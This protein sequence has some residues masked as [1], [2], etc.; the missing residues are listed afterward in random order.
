MKI[1]K[2]TRVR[3]SYKL[4]LENGEVLRVNNI[5]N[6]WQQGFDLN[7]SEL[8]DL[9]KQ[10]Q[11]DKALNR[12]YY[13]LS[14]KDYTQYELETKLKQ[15]SFGYSIIHESLQIIKS[16]GL[17]DERSIAENLLEKYTFYKPEGWHKIKTRLIT[18]GINKEVVNYIVNQAKQ[19]DEFDL[20]WKIVTKKYDKLVDKKKAKI[21][22]S[23][24]NFLLRKGFDIQ[25]AKQ[26]LNK[27]ANEQL[28]GNLE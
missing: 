17:I 11:L 21:E 7:S 12:I 22:Y 24:Y 28:D 25:T 26:V 5:E 2:I 10:D 18:K 8:I 27:L 13:L 15:K 14:L 16:R 23:L 6:R 19:R 4:L 9:K 3:D 20:A 1:K